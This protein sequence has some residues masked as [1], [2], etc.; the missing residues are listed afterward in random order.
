VHAVGTQLTGAAAHAA[1][2]SKPLIRGQWK[3]HSSDHCVPAVFGGETEKKFLCTCKPCTVAMKSQGQ[4][5]NT[6][7]VS[8]REELCFYKLLP[9][10]CSLIRC[11]SSKDERVLPGDDNKYSAL[12]S[13]YCFSCPYLLVRLGLKCPCAAPGIWGWLRQEGVTEVHGPWTALGAEKPPCLFPM[14]GLS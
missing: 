1:I 12:W 4:V 11:W 6:F 13:S 14:A 7:A 8:C 5:W 10:L 9:E 2:L 3:D